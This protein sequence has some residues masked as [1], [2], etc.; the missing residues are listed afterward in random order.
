[1]PFDGQNF[2]KRRDQP[3]RTPPNDATVTLIIVVTATCLF[4]L[5]VPAS[6]LVDIIRY[7]FE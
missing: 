7:V 2:P 1:M 3:K 5:P 4:L 6:A